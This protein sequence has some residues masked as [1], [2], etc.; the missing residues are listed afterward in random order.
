MSIKK[1]IM[2]ALSFADERVNVRIN[3]ITTLCFWKYEGML[4]GTWF[5]NIVVYFDY[6]GG[7]RGGWSKEINSRDYSGIIS[8][9]E[10][11]IK[12][13]SDMIADKLI[14]NLEAGYR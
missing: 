12:E 10:T 5:D 14:K 7:V 11:A 4:S 9:V 1:D 6:V 3:N 2:T 8:E 13:Y